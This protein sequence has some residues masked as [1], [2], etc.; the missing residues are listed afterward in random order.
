MPGLPYRLR[1]I[2]QTIFCHSCIFHRRQC[3]ARSPTPPTLEINATLEVYSTINFPEIP[4]ETSPDSI[5]CFRVAL[6]ATSNAYIVLRKKKLITCIESYTKRR[7]F[8]RL[9]QVK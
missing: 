5:Q 2:L 6:I 7:T 9:K 3:Q 1:V 4:E 8:L